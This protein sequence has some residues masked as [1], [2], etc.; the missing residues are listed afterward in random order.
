[1]SAVEHYRRLLSLIPDPPSDVGE[2]TAI[3]ADGCTVD[4]LNGST[5]NVR[6]VAAMGDLV[7]IRDGVIE[8]PAPVLPMVEIE[9]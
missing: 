8:G 3:L 7:Y 9:V 4:L 5:A 6:G 2:V 1:M